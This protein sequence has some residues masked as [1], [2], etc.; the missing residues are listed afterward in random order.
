VTKSSG[1]SALGIVGSGPGVPVTISSSNTTSKVNT[2]GQQKKIAKPNHNNE[3][4]IKDDS[5]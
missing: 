3:V 1:G 5:S 4:E 2:C